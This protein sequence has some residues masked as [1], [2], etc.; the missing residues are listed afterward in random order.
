MSASRPPRSK[1]VGRGFHR[2]FP[3][4]LS[5]RVTKEAEQAAE[6]IARKICEK[7]SSLNLDLQCVVLGVTPRGGFKLSLTRVEVVSDTIIA[8]W[9]LLCQEAGFDSVITYN[10]MHAKAVIHATRAQYPV[11]AISFPG[12]SLPAHPLTLLFGLLLVAN[13]LRKFAV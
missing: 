7:T 5:P 2:G 10:T 6:N 3:G 9:K 12:F 8:E 13:T 11:S 4:K 1:S